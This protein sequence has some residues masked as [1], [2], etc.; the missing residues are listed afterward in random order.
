MQ[1]EVE[2]VPERE[3]GPEAESDSHIETREEE[4]VIIAWAEKLEHPGPEGEEHEW[5]MFAQRSTMFRE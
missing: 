2:Q 4:I 1:Q 5:R 3:H